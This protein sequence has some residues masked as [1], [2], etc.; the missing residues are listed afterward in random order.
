VPWRVKLKL[1]FSRPDEVEVTAWMS[2]TAKP[3]LNDVCPEMEKQGLVATV[4]EEDDKLW[5]T[6]DHGDQ[7]EFIYGLE[8]KFYK[9]DGYAGT[10]ADDEVGYARAEVFLREGGQHYD[11]FGYTKAQLIRDL[12]RQYERHRQWIHHMVNVG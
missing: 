3:A 12:L 6:V 1:M 11:I 5:I 7:P 2:E 8:L 4:V 10:V 9:G